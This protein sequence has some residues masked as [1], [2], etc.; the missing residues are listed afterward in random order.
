MEEKIVAVSDYTNFC[1]LNYDFN[2]GDPICVRHDSV[3]NFFDPGKLCANPWIREPSILGYISGVERGL[4]WTGT[5]SCE[6]L[7]PTAVV[8]HRGHS[9]AAL[10]ALYFSCSLF[11]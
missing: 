7:P 1:E 10:K 9:P 8:V 3:V 6:H 11:R 4:M 2:A 5:Y